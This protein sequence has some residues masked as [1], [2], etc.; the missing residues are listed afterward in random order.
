MKN[1]SE[2]NVVF[3]KIQGFLNFFVVFLL[4][5]YFILRFF[6][7]PHTPWIILYKIII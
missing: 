7:N 4:Q 3:T 6:L 5:V 2:D 1:R